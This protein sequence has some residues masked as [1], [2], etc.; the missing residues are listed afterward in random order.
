MPTMTRYPTNAQLNKFKDLCG[1]VYESYRSPEEQRGDYVMTHKKVLNK[2]KVFV[3]MLGY[4][5]VTN[6]SSMLSFVESTEQYE[7]VSLLESMTDQVDKT[8][9]D[10]NTVLHHA[11]ERGDRPSVLHLLMNGV[12]YDAINLDGESALHIAAETGQLLV[13]RDLLKVGANIFGMDDISCSAHKSYPVLNH[14]T[15]DD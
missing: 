5:G 9:S 13:V 8:D 3:L 14:S 1:K 12:D 10:G 6:I 11:V 15:S 2:V 7:L 4:K